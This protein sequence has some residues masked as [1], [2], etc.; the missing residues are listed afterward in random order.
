M[1]GLESIAMAIINPEIINTIYANAHNLELCH[2][3]I[4]QLSDDDISEE[5]FTLATLIAGTNNSNLI[6]YAHESL[7]L[8]FV[9]CDKYGYTALHLAAK[10]NQIVSL[11]YICENTDIDI[12]LKTN[13]GYTPLIC[14]ASYGELELIKYLVLEQ[15]ANVH[16]KSY[17]G[18]SLDYYSKNN[19]AQEVQ[20]YITHLL[21]A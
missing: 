17:S 6:K 18:K 14:A 16:V 11:K 10:F 9:K 12:E 19:P 15:N 8:D 13:T 1:R 20:N 4:S 2:N 3:L 21:G 7:K 5:G